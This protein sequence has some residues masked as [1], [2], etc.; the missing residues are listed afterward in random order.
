MEQL[1]D[2][3]FKELSDMLEMVVRRF[4]VA[5]SL[6][7]SKNNDSA[8]STDLKAS[9]PYELYLNRVIDAYECLSEQEQNLINNEF[10]YQSYNDWWKAIYSKS[11]F[12]KCKKAAMVKFL[13]VFYH[14]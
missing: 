10:F 5:R 3:S 2:K 13:E 4:F 1:N 7:Q 11:Y 12:Y 8:L 14:A 9:Y 6:Q